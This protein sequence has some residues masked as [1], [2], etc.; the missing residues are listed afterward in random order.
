MCATDDSSIEKKY[1]K[2]QR[3]SKLLIAKGKVLR[4]I[5]RKYVYYGN[6][7]HRKEYLRS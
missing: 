1:V 6:V 7:Y 5:E 4:K 2:K 3:E